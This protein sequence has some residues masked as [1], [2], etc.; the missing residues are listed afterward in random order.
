[1][2]EICVSISDPP[3][4]LSSKD[5]KIWKACYSLLA[6]RINEFCQE[7]HA[8]D[9]QNAIQSHSVMENLDDFFSS[10]RFDGN[11]GALDS[12]L[13][14]SYIFLKVIIMEARAE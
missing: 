5:W 6:S 13:E 2:D 10:I 7:T 12:G 1:M 11:V 9:S 4:S 3:I 8:K 14:F